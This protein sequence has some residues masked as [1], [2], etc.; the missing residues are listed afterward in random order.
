MGRYSYKSLERAERKR[1]ADLARRVKE[2]AKQTEL[3]AAKQAVDAFEARVAEVKSAHRQC[4]EPVNWLGFA[5]AMPPCV[6]IPTGWREKAARRSRLILEPLGVESS[7][8]PDVSVAIKN[9]AAV[10]QQQEDEWR[11]ETIEHERMTGLAQAIL[12]QETDAY[13]QALRDNPAWSELAEQGSTVELT[14][15]SPNLVVCIFT[16]TT[17][18]VI[19]TEVKSLTSTGKLSSKAM[20][21]VQFMAL[22][23]DFLCSCVL[24]IGREV[25]A[26]LPVPTVLVTV[27]CQD[28]SAPATPVISVILARERFGKLDFETVDPSDAVETFPC[29][30]DFKASRKSESFKS[31]V[32]FQPRDVAPPA[33][34][35]SVSELA[36]RARELFDELE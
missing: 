11:Q 20:P 35:A 36:A 18:A 27:N 5:S 7:E 9:D 4:T 19:P 15:S 10:L 30:T 29:R 26:T 6:P 31:I 14:V 34:G 3:E 28:G 24:R 33:R 23:Q 25:F 22:Y 8:L 17:A 16:A 32:P 21:R 2:Q 13:F 1:A 12:R